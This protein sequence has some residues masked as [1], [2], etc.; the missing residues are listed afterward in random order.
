MTI[1]FLDITINLSP[2]FITSPF[3]IILYCPVAERD[4]EDLFSIYS[5]TVSA[6]VQASACTTSASAC[7][8]ELVLRQSSNIEKLSSVIR[9][10]RFKLVFQCGQFGSY[11]N[12]DSGTIRIKIHQLFSV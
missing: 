4:E 9:K 7:T 3:F 10:F 11:I 6:V 2:F 8:S 5:K 1:F 12:F